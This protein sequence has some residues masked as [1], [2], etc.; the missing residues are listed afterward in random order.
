MWKTRA[1]PGRGRH[2]P[3]R[4]SHPEWGL[5]CDPRKLADSACTC[6]YLDLDRNPSAS[7]R[8]ETGT[9]HVPSRRTR[10]GPP[11]HSSITPDGADGLMSK[12]VNGLSTPYRTAPRRAAAWGRRTG[13]Q[14]GKG[15]EKG[16]GQKDTGGRAK[17]W[18]GA[19]QGRVG[20]G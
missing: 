1:P 3:P 18:A 7:A 15:R 6:R 10:G 16:K 5:I 11:T 8:T 12:C 4:Q 14:K 9:G 17:T 13:G 20:Q 19:W 2:S